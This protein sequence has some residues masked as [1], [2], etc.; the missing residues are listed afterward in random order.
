[1]G[2]GPGD[3]FGSELVESGVSGGCIEERKDKSY[4]KCIFNTITTM[5]P[6]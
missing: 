4:S 1:V 3:I 5:K 2:E 6:M